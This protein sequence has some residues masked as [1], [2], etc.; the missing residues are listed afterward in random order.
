M[1]FSKSEHLELFVKGGIV[2][3]MI[4]DALGFPFN[5]SESI[6]TL[7]KIDMK[8]SEQPIGS[9]THASSLMICTIASINELGGFQADDLM[10]KFHDFY[11]AGTFT[12]GGECFELDVT[13]IQAIKNH[14]T[15]MPTDRCGLKDDQA[16][17]NNA[18]IRML[19]IGLFYCT[20]P[21][22][23]LIDKVQES[24]RL[25]HNT[26]SNEVCCSLYALLVRNIVTQT[27]EKIFD[28][29]QAHYEEK[30]ALEYLD[31]L[32][33]VKTWRDDNKPCAGKYVVDSF[34]TAWN[35]FSANQSDFRRCVVNSM[36]SG[37]SSNVVG[38]L[39]GGL[40]ALQNGVNDIPYRW[41]TALRLMD[42]P[43]TATEIT[44]FVNY[45]VNKLIRL[46]LKTP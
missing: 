2:G 31:H 21:A 38:A 1:T 3:H 14:S 43:E 25:T 16:K 36:K 18:L 35:A 6:P 41:I 8:A 22:S 40:S 13:T 29:L 32:E 7:D 42:N 23:T 39:A 44:K 34:W 30:E 37:N 28:V 10:E 46:N 20:D 26:I 9:Y 45:V 27:S 24:C 19:P 12:P 15:G 5:N 17:N 4:G 33:F 11:V